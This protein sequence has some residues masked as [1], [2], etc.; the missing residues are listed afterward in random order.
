MA[1][2]TRQQVLSIIEAAVTNKDVTKGKEVETKK[3][4]T[5][6]VLMEI[7]GFAGEPITEVKVGNKVYTVAVKLSVTAYE[8]T[9]SSAVRGNDLL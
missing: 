6:Y 3:G 1:Q 7:G 9:A 2:T 4:R 5:I 8:K